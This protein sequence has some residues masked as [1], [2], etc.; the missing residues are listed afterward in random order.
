MHTNRASE[1]ND[2]LRPQIVPQEEH[3][4]RHADH[5]RT[6][7]HHR[8]ADAQRTIG[9]ERMRRFQRQSHMT[10]LTDL[11][12][13]PAPA[14]FHSHLFWGGHLYVSEPRG[15]ARFV[16]AERGPRAA[17]GPIGAP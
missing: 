3:V 14:G 12:A 11:G 5:D 9:G 13:D 15:A 2:V 16:W 7:A 10:A 8:L 1:G 6:A 4:M 17:P